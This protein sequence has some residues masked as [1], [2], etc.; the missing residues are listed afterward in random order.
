MN[1]PEPRAV[2]H[3]RDFE[4]GRAFFR[5]VLG[6]DET[7]VD[8]DE[9]WATLSRGQMHIAV[10]QG[11]PDDKGGVAMIDVDDI[12][13]EADRLRGAGVSVGT[14]VEL[15]GEMRICDVFDPDGNRIQLS[16]PL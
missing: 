10:T 8:F 12:R 6:F 1:A 14:I 13:A 7:I 2:Y 4:Q 9:R 5:E 16:Q 15:V 3:V 11:E